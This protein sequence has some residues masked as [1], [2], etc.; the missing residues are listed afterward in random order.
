[1]PLTSPEISAV[2]APGA[3]GKFSYFIGDHGKTAALFSGPGRLDRR[4]ERQQIGL[5]GNFADQTDDAA[6]ALGTFAQGID[7][8]RRVTK[9]GGVI[10]QAGRDRPA[11]VCGFRALRGGLGSAACF[12]RHDAGKGRQRRTETLE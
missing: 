5:I 12:S 11:A 6:D 3:L 1:M 10:E 4:I 7:A 2:A 8:A 9:A